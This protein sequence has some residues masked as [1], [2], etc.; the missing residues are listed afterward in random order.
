[1]NLS[2]QFHPFNQN[3]NKM[4]NRLNQKNA[5]MVIVVLFSSFASMMVMLIT[6]PK[7]IWVD[8]PKVGK[9][10]IL[11]I[12]NSI[13]DLK[14]FV[15]NHNYHQKTQFYAVQPQEKTLINETQ[16]NHP[17]YNIVKIHFKGNIPSTT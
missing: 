3:P 14:N 15:K 9:N 12:H 6:Y 2:I 10:A 17:D 13:N 4:F 16:I 5:L 1:M 7:T 8:A 11:Q